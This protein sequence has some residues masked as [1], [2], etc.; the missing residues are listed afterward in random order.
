MISTRTHESTIQSTN[1]P[2]A[3]TTR[4]QLAIETKRARLRNLFVAILLFQFVASITIWLTQW[5]PPIIGFG[6]FSI[7]VDFRLLLYFLLGSIAAQLVLLAYFLAFG[8]QKVWRR[9][10][11][12][13]G[14]LI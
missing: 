12:Y 2:S 4:I 5:L 7:P 8:P 3:S 11:V 13:L 6:S 9:L 1:T 14:I 10:I